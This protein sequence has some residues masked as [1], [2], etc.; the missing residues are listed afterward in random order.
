MDSFLDLNR[1]KRLPFFIFPSPLNTGSSFQ[2]SVMI[3]DND[4]SSDLSRPTLPHLEVHVHFPW[5]L[6][7][8]RV[9]HHPI[10]QRSVA[11]WDSPASNKRDPHT[12]S[13]GWRWSTEVSSNRW[14]SNQRVRGA[15][16]PRPKETP[17][18][19]Q[20]KSSIDHR[21]PP[22]TRQRSGR[23]CRFERCPPRI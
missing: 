8:P 22:C 23:R 4:K 17:G 7:E 16:M 2:D 20:Q 1:S 9:Q 12:Q 10:C 18:L 13:L 11:T 5:Q 6:F 3:K 19:C 21:Q 14:W 15:A